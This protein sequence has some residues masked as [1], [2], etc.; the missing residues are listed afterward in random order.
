MNL[1]LPPER[2]LPDAEQM[3]QRIISVTSP[4]PRRWWWLV[5]LLTIAVL[6][7]S[8]TG[9]L[10]RQPIQGLATPSQS[11][12]AEQ[13]TTSPEPS[14]TPESTGPTGDAVEGNGGTLTRGC[15]VDTPDA[16]TQLLDEYRMAAPLSAATM[17]GVLE[18]GVDGQ[19]VSERSVDVDER[20]LEFGPI[21][22]SSSTTIDRIG[23]QAI[24]TNFD[25]DGDAFLFTSSV[26]LSAERRL[27]RPGSEPVTVDS[28]RD[29]A[30][31]P[32]QHLQARHDGMSIW[33]ALEPQT[34]GLWLRI[35]QD[36]GAVREAELG[37][38]EQAGVLGL[39]TQGGNVW[40]SMTDGTMRGFD[41]ESGAP[42]RFPHDY[43]PVSSA[44]IG[45]VFSDGV[46][47]G[48]VRPDGVTVMLSPDGDFH[49]LEIDTTDTRLW[50]VSRDFVTWQQGSG[51][52]AQWWI[53]DMRTGG[54]TTF[55]SAATKLGGSG[56]RNGYLVVQDDPLRPAVIPLE[57]L[58][59]L[60][61]AC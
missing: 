32:Y 12:S 29:A 50:S 31:L 6:A 25:T 38:I 4:R 20:W 45:A 1:R 33:L 56:V 3:L 55:P 54:L 13:T 16:W 27:W 36:S 26:G 52:A 30:L 24:V 11:R 21:D 2:D 8:A 14:R 41:L 35:S 17:V 57:R 61:W 18:V 49:A 39:A 58:G 19:V 15:P 5:L 9:M 47:L 37:S 59:M 53:W 46:R 7:L 10:R 28:P 51:P 48:M 22:R 60:Y 44:P 23:A 42:V 40:L 34:R 43:N